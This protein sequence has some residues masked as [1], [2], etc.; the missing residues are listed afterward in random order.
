MTAI[1]STTRTIALI[2]ASNKP[3][4]PSYGVMGFLL[5]K[6][7][8]VHPVNPGLA[9]GEI[10]GQQVYATLADCPAPIDMVD[11]FRN[12]ADAAT[13]IDEAIACKDKLH[14]QTIWCQ[15]G[16]TPHE[17]ASRAQAAGLTVV[18]DRCP[19]IDWR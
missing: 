9:G 17:A 3:E 16:V 13:V 7:Y 11:I 10:Q 2:G 5:A 6:G 1:Q 14:I 18:M 15:L 8:I 12:T 19:A 4:R